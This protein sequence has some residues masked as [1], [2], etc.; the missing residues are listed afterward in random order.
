MQGLFKSQMKLLKEKMNEDQD[1][2]DGEEIDDTYPLVMD[3]PFSN[4]DEEHIRNVCLTL[5]E[6]CNQLIMVM[7]RKD[8]KI[9][10]DKIFEIWEHFPLLKNEIKGEG[11]FGKDYIEL[12]FKNGSR[13]DVVGALDSERGGRRNGGLID[14]V[15]DHDGE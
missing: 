13:F 4:T 12:R 2:L 5:P 14:E 1:I 3:A 10:K 6:Y 11:N 9:A 7:I 8:Y 15:R